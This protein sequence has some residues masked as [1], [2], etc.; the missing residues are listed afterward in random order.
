MTM[1]LTNINPHRVTVL[2]AQEYGML[3]AKLQQHADLQTAP[4]DEPV[5]K[6]PGDT[7]TPQELLASAVINTSIYG[8]PKSSFT[9]MAEEPASATDDRMAPS[10]SEMSISDRVPEPSIVSSIDHDSQLF[11]EDGLIPAEEGIVYVPTPPSR[12]HVDCSKIRYRIPKQTSGAGNSSLQKAL[13]SAIAGQELDIKNALMEAV[14]GEDIKTPQLLLDFSANPNPT[15]AG[16]I[17]PLRT[18]C[19]LNQEAE[20]DLLIEWGADPNVLASDRAP[21]A[22][23]T[24]HKNLALMNLLLKMARIRCRECPPEIAQAMLH[25]GANPDLKDSRGFSAGGGFFLACRRNQPHLVEMLLSHGADPNMSRPELPVIDAARHPQCLQALLHGK[26]DLKKRRGIMELATYHNSI[27]SARMLLDV[28]VDPNEKSQN[29]YTPLNIAIHDNRPELMT[30]LLSRGADPNL[31]ESVKIL[32]DAGVDPN[33][34][35]DGVYS[36]PTSAIRD[37]RPE[38]QVLVLSGGADPNL[39]GQAIP[40]V[41]AKNRVEIFNQLV[42]GGEDHAKCSGV[43]ESAVYHNNIASVKFLLDA[44]ASPNDKNQGVYSPLTSAIRDTRPDILQ[45]LLERGADPNMK[46]QDVPLVMAVRNSAIL[47]QLIAGG[48]DVTKH[49]G[50]LELAVYHNKMESIDILLEAAA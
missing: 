40:L 24:Y 17:T 4:V 36:P 11:I 33:E 41:M 5:A 8:T 47:R 20:A 48:A 50:L 42:E 13:L 1:L 31:K 38:I 27:D 46:G 39:K 18:A 14:K 12:L 43:L 49:Q 15:L 21:L 28:G 44:G 25:Y 6:L 30:L 22:Y 16:G 23:A 7:Q 32:L 2:S 29:I 45:V 26:V 19:E 3:A 37:N 34:K 35:K 10:V 9:S